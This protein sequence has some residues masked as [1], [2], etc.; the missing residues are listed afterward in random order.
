MA[1][2]PT[3]ATCPPPVAGVYPGS[4]V[5][6]GDLDTCR[7]QAGETSRW[8]AGWLLLQSCR[9]V[10]IAQPR[11]HGPSSMLRA[12]MGQMTS[13]AHPRDPNL[14]PQPLFNAESLDGG[15]QAGEMVSPAHLHRPVR[16]PRLCLV[17]RAQMRENKRGRWCP[18]RLPIFPVPSAQLRLRTMDATMPQQGHKGSLALW[19]DTQQHE[20][21]LHGVKPAQHPRSE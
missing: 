17:L 4:S 5:P 16:S 19:E 18:W 7:E 8:G 10:P 11:P 13:P 2:F 21:I 12:Q 1:S 6:A 3:R 9:H 20:S 14:S 15:E